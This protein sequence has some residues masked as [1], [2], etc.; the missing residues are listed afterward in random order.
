MPYDTTASIEDKYNKLWEASVANLDKIKSSSIAEVDNAELE[1]SNIYQKQVDQ[2]KKDRQEGSVTYQKERSLNDANLAKANKRMTEVAASRNWRGG[3][4]IDVV[5]KGSQKRVQAISATNKKEAE[6]NTQL[7]TSATENEKYYN[8][9]KIAARKQKEKIEADY[10]SQR[11]QARQLNDAQRS[12]ELSDYRLRQQQRDFQAS[13]SELQRMNE[14]NMSNSS[15]SSGG[16]AGY[17]TGTKQITSAVMKYKD[18]LTQYTEKYG[19]SQYRDLLL[20]KIMQEAGGSPGALATDPMQ[21]SESAGHSV[22]YFRNPVDS[23]NQ[24][25]KYFAQILAKAGGDVPLA[26]QSYNFGEGFIDYVK[27][28]GGKM[29]QS[30]VNSFSDMMAKKMGWRSYGD[31][32]YVQNVLRYY[33]AKDP[34]VNS[35]TDH[36]INFASGK[37]GGKYV[38][39]GTGGSDGRSYDCS[40]LTQA[41][42]KS[43]G[44]SIPRVSQDQFRA[45]KAV[46]LNDLRAGDLVFFATDS[47]GGASHVG[48]YAGNGQMIHAANTRVGIVKVNFNEYITRVKYLGGR[49]YI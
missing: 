19:V 23:I 27:K 42:Y 11:L 20:A 24:G 4:L 40:G 33:Q 41:M 49:R 38:W 48:V 30:L 6:Y 16:F 28:N 37:L 43:I 44:I 3:E 35:K 18:L 47:T 14:L 45:G 17:Q 32:N 39:G 31:K 26:L 21:S 36:M 7:D 46:G 29:T 8:E 10:N 2:I 25:V 22:G 15:Y 5:Q 1:A 34:Y 12:A 9:Q 13:Q